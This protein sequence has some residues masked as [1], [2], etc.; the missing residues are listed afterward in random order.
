MKAITI[1]SLLT[2]GICLLG[3]VS[4]TACEEPNILEVTHNYNIDAGEKRVISIVLF[5]NDRLDLSVTCLSHDIGLQVDNP[6]GQT[7]IP[8]TR[9][10][11]GNFIV[12]AKENGAYV[13]TLDNSYS[14]FTPKSVTLILTYPER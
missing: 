13:V 14:L 9:I 2:L 4:V 5:E 10:E 7:E 8:F 6:S 12:N 1:I 11:S 3:A